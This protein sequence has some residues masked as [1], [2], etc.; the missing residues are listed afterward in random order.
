MSV[1][2]DKATALFAELGKLTPLAI[3]ERV[4]DAGIVGERGNTTKCP[5]ALLVKKELGFTVSIGG[6]YWS[7]VG[8]LHDT[9]TLP[10]S[11]VAFIDAVDNRDPAFV[12]IATEFID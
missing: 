1:N 8:E 7:L 5:L 12:D 3:G 9:H 6:S 2:E 10:R 4:R 11:C